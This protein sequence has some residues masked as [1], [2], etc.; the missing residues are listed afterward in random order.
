[1]NQISAILTERNK[2]SRFPYRRNKKAILE[3]EHEVYLFADRS[4]RTS[5]ETKAP[6]DHFV[7]PSRSQPALPIHVRNVSFASKPLISPIPSRR[8]E[9]I[10]PPPPEEVEEDDAAIVEPP[11][12]PPPR[13]AQD[14]DQV[15]AEDLEQDTPDPTVWI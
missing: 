9:D 5:Q 10:P 15:G 2:H 6:P 14:F 13:S 1:L 4:R 3:Q 7:S 11:L 12:P 8:G